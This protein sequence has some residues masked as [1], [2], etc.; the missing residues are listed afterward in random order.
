MLTG[1]V[2]QQTAVDAV[3]NGSIFRFVNK[4][5]PPEKLGLIFDEGLQHYQLLVA[6]KELL[7]KTLAGCVGLINEMLS[8]ANPKAFGRGGRVRRWIKQLCQEMNLEDAWQFEV[9]AMLSQVGCIANTVCPTTSNDF[10][11]TQ[12]QLR[13]QAITS[14]SIIGHI[15][16][17][18]DISAM[19]GHQYSEEMDSTIP[20]S[21]RLGAKMLRMSFP[22]TVVYCLATVMSFPRA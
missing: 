13:I 2:D 4:P 19:I 18:E 22:S 5:C 12:R 17:L 10:A 20:K 1:N 21:V 9:A 11:T 14:S 7:S 16:R 3:N 15:P 6:E 8:I